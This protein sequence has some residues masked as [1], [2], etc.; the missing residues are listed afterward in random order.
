MSKELASV[1][2]RAIGPAIASGR[3]SDFAV[4]PIQLVVLVWIQIMLRLSGSE[5]G[6]IIIN[7]Q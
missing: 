6:R 7:V 1:S 3:I 4:N 2:W 5:L